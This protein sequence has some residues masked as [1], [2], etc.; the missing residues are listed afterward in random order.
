MGLIVVGLWFLY[1][2]RA[3]LTPFVF[4]GIFSYIVNPVVKFFSRVFRLPKIG[5]IVLLY[6]L[7]FALTA[8]VGV[9]SSKTI[10]EE[11]TELN[12]VVTKVLIS[13]KS[14]I[15]TLPDW[16]QPVTTDYI[17]SLQKG[18][19]IPS[20]QSPQAS[21]PLFSAALLR[22]A[23]FFIFIFSGFYFLK[24]GEAFANKALS[25]IPSTY[26]VEV[27]ILL[28]KIN[29]ILGGYLRG[30]VLLVGIVALGL[31]I[32]LLIVGVKFALIIAIFSGFAEI[33]PFIGPIVAGAL[34]VLVVLITG[35]ANFGLS[36]I[37]ASLIVILIYFIVRQLEDYFVIPHVMHRIT[38]LPAFVIF[39]AVIAGGHI[40][41][42]VGLIL[43]VP[44]AAIVRLLVEFSLDTFSTKRMS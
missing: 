11:S 28:R 24:D 18:K 44:L 15:Q 36:P 26:R 21:L 4:A 39:F 30:E 23:S 12:R 25:L 33:V 6:L 22:V 34:A 37:N 3:I 2:E 20:L 19:F 17:T 27:E 38:K 43:A 8:T 7:I 42:V 14:D 5:S 41:G 29:A 35:T 10:A 9:I 31:Y 32:A 13:T 40:G 16:L 1:I